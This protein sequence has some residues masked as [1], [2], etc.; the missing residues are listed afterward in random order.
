MKK[1][2]EIYNLPRL[3]QGEIE[4]VKT[5]IT[6]NEIKSVI[7]KKKNFQQTKNSGPDGITQELYQIFREELTSILLKLFQKKTAEKGI[8]P[9]S[10]YVITLE[11]K[12][13]IPQERN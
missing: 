8:L 4:N 2:L 6:S 1:F 3:N 11:P 13:K 12:S 7:K 10:F 9:N 5:S